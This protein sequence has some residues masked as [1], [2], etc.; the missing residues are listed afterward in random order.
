[1]TKKTNN[2][3]VN[4]NDSITKLRNIAEWFESQEDVDIEAGLLK[5]KEGALLVKECKNRLKDLENT[6]NEIK[7]DLDLAN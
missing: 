4:L 7:K 5:I 6:F 2:D 1:M 3:E